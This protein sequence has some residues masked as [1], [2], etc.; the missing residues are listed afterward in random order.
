MLLSLTIHNFILIDKIE[1]NF[2]KGFTVIT[3]ETGSGKSL[4]ID[5]LLYCLG[6]RLST[7]IIRKHTDKGF[8]ESVFSI[9]LIPH[10]K[11]ALQANNYEVN[12]LL[13]IRRE[14]TNKG[15]SRCF[16]NDS[17]ATQSF[18][19]VIASSL[20]DFHGQHENQ[21]LL[22]H[23]NHLAVLDAIAHLETYIDTYYL[24]WNQLQQSIFSYQDLIKQELQLL[25]KKEYSLFQLHE[26][27]DIS[28]EPTEL[29]DLEHQLSVIQHAAKL[30]ESSHNLYVLLYNSE[31]SARD[32]LIKS[33]L[34]LQQLSTIDHSFQLYLDE[35]TQAIA[36]ISEISTFASA[37]CSSL[38]FEDNTIN[39]IQERLSLLYRLK[40]KY[41]SYDS[42]FNIWNQLKEDIRI[43]SNFDDELRIK[44][45]DILR[46]KTELSVLAVELSEKRIAAAYTIKE[47]IELT[48]QSIGI[49]HP[50]F[51]V[52]IHQ[53][54]SLHNEIDAMSMSISIHN[55]YVK[56]KSSGIDIVEFLIST[57][58]GEI[59]KPLSKAASGGEISRIMLAIKAMMA[60][61]D[62]IPVIVF[63]EIDTGIS[64]RIAQKV[65]FL[66]QD[67]GSKRQVIAISHSP[68]IAALADNHILVQKKII[69]DRAYVTTTLL[70]NA[71]KI[72]HIAS[73]IS[74]NNITPS[75]YE[76]A[77]ELIQAKKLL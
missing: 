28:P 53:I 24:L 57:N 69:D 64:G 10:I 17:P 48:L 39:R 25:E 3:G 68:Q 9:E 15:T 4:I 49:E 29:S 36:S 1:I 16:I 20:A 62:K 22:H 6:E 37:Y 60:H 65:G 52:Q 40:K 54:P 77:L 42:I 23:E 5:A 72:E 21:L 8:V 71:E 74:G 30:Y 44:K 73:L 66:I 31:N 58:P 61:I 76:H 12:P 43:A 63:D 2:N 33:Q 34:L 50:I 56:V 38:N 13:I 47:S 26:I 27:E 75:S 41:G 67:I 59:P 70:S 46:I 14:F 18:V 55:D 45:E 11:A 51:S 7:D 35:C 32:S 19:K